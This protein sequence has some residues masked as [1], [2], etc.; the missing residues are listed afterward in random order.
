MP[1][2]SSL[3]SKLKDDVG[4]VSWSWLRPHEKHGILFLAAERLDLVEVAVEVAEDRILQIKTW[5]E[6]GDLIRP[7]PNQVA[8]WEKSGGLFSGIIVKPYV[9]FKPVVIN[10]V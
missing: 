8:E 4:T 9:F 5:L 2:D 3:K 7:A 1:E 6:N 10:E